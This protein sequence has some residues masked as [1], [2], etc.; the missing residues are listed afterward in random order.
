MAVMMADSTEYTVQEVAE[1]A[2]VTA[3]TLHYYDQIGLLPPAARTDAGYR[4]YSEEQLLRLQG[5]LF[6]RELGFELSEIGELI[7]SPN[8]ER[9][10]ALRDQRRLLEAKRARLAVLIRTINRTIERIEEE[11]PMLSDEQLYEG[12]SQEEIERYKREARQR[13]GVDNVEQTEQRVR[14][15]SASQWKSVQEE[16]GRIAASLS[17]LMGEPADSPTVQSQIE[18][19]HA[20]IENFYPA[21]AEV[22]AGLGDLYVQDDRF[23]EFYDQYASGLAEFIKAGIDHYCQTVLAA[24]PGGSA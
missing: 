3:R 7:D 6:Y 18:R 9:L 20:W 23:R 14:K 1:M 24:E 19:H 15:L 11:R 2:G 10:S 8:F 16:G 21:P 5:I 17:E 22:Y 13:Y 4:L 12:F